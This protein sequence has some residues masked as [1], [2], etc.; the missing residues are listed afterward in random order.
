MS[1]KRI[2]FSKTGGFPTTQNTLDFMQQAYVHAIQA[3]ADL[4]GNRVIISGMEENNNQIS[5]GW[6]V[7]DGELL[8]FTGGP[9]QTHILIE[10]ET[11]S[12]IFEGEASSTEVYHTRKAKFGGS[13]LLYSDLVRL[14]KIKVLQSN[15]NDLTNALNSHKE[16]FNN[17]HQVTKAQVGLGNL[18]NEVGTIH[19][20][21]SENHA[22]ASIEAVKRAYQV[23]YSGREFIDDVSG[24][25]TKIT[26]GHNAHIVAMLLEIENF[27][28][29]DYL[30]VGSIV[31]KKGDWRDD[32]NV[33]WTVRNKTENSFE[34]CLLERSSKVQDI[35][36]EWAL[37]LK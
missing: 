20:L 17:P 30:V 10:E 26:V 15:L 14:D 7:W 18:P 9:K 12:V 33:I 34:L 2:D 25:G 8:P 13:T 22:L 24:S 4:A 31:S 23:I 21:L 37:I 3:L 6:I 16:D 19:P 1:N 35:E 29:E 27:T 5:D 32:T 36:F 28:G 11:E